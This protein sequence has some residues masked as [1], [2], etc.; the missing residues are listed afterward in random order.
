VYILRG[1]AV[2][3]VAMAHGRRRPGYWQSRL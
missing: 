3:V 2:E 1:D